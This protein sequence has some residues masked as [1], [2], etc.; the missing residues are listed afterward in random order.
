M[1][2]KE[3]L[4]TIKDKGVVMVDLKFIDLLGTWQHFSA[5][6]PSSKMKGHSRKGWASTAPRYAAGSQST[7]A[8]CSWSPIRAPR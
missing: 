6:S 7:R 3:V 1:T 8:T 2:P 4:Q 5:P